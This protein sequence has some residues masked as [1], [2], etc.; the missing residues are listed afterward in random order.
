MYKQIVILFCSICFASCLSNKAVAVTYLIIGTLDALPSS[1]VVEIQ[2][3][4]HTKETIVI[5]S[6]NSAYGSIE[7]NKTKIIKAPRNTEIKVM[8]GNSGFT[9]SILN[10]SSSGEFYTIKQNK[11]AN[12][13]TNID[14]STYEDPNYQNS[15]Y[16]KK[17]KEAE[18]INR[19]FG[20]SK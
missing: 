7:K 11:Y 3:E 6:D 10:C 20:L 16:A 12:Q 19:V 1:D 9:Y 14:P 13:N 8:G 18:N 17:K 5:L 2:I 15:E 4:N